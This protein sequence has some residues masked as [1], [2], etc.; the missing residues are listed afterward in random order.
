MNAPPY[1]DSLNDAQKKA[2][3]HTSGP[4]MIIAGAG[5][6]KTRVL[7]YRIA[8]LIRQEIPA[9]N[10]LA[11]TFT[12]K[13][14]K[15][16]KARIM[17]ICGNEARNLW[18][19]T[20]HSV[21]AKILRIEAD[22]LNYPSN[23]TI[24][25]T[26][27]SKSLLKSIIKEMN[28]DDKNYKPNVIYSRISNAKNN[29]ISPE[30]YQNAEDLMSYDYKSGRPKFLEI[31]KAYRDRCFRAGAMDF[32][33][34]LM[35]TDKLLRKHPD[36]LLKYQHK[37]QYIMV[38]EYQDTNICQYSIV[39]RLAAA[40]ENICVVGDDAQSIYSFRGA[41]I[42]NILNFQKDYSDA[43]VYK[44][45]Q[46]YRSTQIIV[47]AA[48]KIIS[49]NKEQ[50]EKKVWTANDQGDKIKLIRAV[51]DNEEG[52]LIAEDIFEQKMKNQLPNDSFAI[53]YRTNYQSRSFE[54]ALRKKSLAYRIYGGTS[55]YQR[56]EVKDLLAY[57]RLTLNP[58]DEEALKRIINYP[59]RKIGNTTIDK[60]ILLAS[61][62][63][64][65]IYEIVLNAQR[66]EMLG[67]A[68]GAVQKF[69]LMMESFRSLLPTHNAYDI[70]NH[71]AKQSGILRHLHE[72]KTVEGVSRYENLVELLNG[73]K[74]FVEDDT[75]E[76]QK[77]LATFLEEIALLTDADKEDKDEEP[78]IS[79]MTIHASK[80]LE[81]PYVYVVGLEENLFPS[82][83]ALNSRADLEEE[84]RLF[85]VALTRA[86]T[87]LCL[88]FATSRFRFGSLLNSEPSRFIEELGND[89]IEMEALQSRSHQKTILDKMNN[90][91]FAR[92]LVNNMRKTTVGKSKLGA[93][94]QIDPNFVPDDTSNIKIDDLVR[95]NRFGKGKVL[96]IDGSGNA[97]KVKIDFEEVGE[98][99]LV[100]SFAKLQILNS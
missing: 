69:G 94:N 6:G 99:T 44:L 53:L 39:K 57:L 65:S 49:R 50:L 32:D 81:F 25:D 74:E 64:C 38:D 16:M 27:D 9:F 34:I 8:H 18:M 84:R 36:V 92:G 46:N 48:G 77:D 78:K 19:G 85:Y 66:F 26:D 82:Q 87:R 70:A 58:K 3:L 52:K 47:D 23:F 61:Q 43:A 86:E 93:Q 56:K 98:K 14:A 37:F 12:N 24:Y 29:L 68:L 31:Y 71:I 21:F 5:S 15:E 40:H 17:Q 42:Q 72:D 54:E 88:S 2:V 30:A 75:A 63:Q 73:I 100:L 89:Y 51:T 76:N 35:N 60:L 96:A 59:A 45:E 97:T 4:V 67:R 33:D 91:G 1:L 22:R 79:L 80:G 28:L 90:S 83:M 10:I 95:H 55:F 7:T 11:L 20:F 62:H 13:A 41:T